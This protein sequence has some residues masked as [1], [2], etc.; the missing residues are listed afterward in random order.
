M[1]GRLRGPVARL[2]LC[3]ARA[4]GNKAKGARDVALQTANPGYKAFKN[5]RSPTNFDKKVLV[6]AGRFKKE[7]DIPKHISSEV[8]DA[9]RS[10]VRIKVCYI[11]IALTLLGCLAMVITGKE[12]AKRDHTLLRM[13]IEKKAK[14]KAEVEKDQEAAL[15]KSQ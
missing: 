10:S 11:M 6:W 14:W 4:A 8:L 5:D 7:E 15:G 3:P 12:A 9:A 2:V 1:L 13:N